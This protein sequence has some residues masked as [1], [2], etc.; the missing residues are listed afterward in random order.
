MKHKLLEH[1]AGVLF[2]TLALVAVL[3]AVTVLVNASER[4]Q[5][6]GMDQFGDL[7]FINFN[8]RFDLALLRDAIDI[9]YPGRA[10]R[11]DSLFNAVV[12]HRQRAF[13]EKL[14]NT[15]VAEKLSWKRAAVIFGMYARFLLIYA[16]VMVLTYYGV[17]TLAVL[18]FV[19]KK[20][21]AAAPALS[22]GRK[23]RRWLVSLLAGGGVF[24]LFC[25]AYVI[26]YSI[27]T[28]FNTDT[29]VFLVLLGVVSNGVLITYANKFYAFLTAE[30]RKGYV[31]TAMVK[32]L[33]AGYRFHGRDGITPASIFSPV[34]KFRNHVFDHVFR[35]ARSQYLSTIKEQASF[36]ITGLII[37]EMALNIH[38]YLNY[39]M[40]RQLL[41]RNYSIVVVM[42]LLIFYTVKMTEIYSD[43]LVHRENRK[44]ENA[45]Q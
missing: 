34:K 29:V 7:S 42:M 18:R 45:D 26:A 38:G 37:I 43:Y 2:V 31:A 11:N 4:R 20:R 21:C 23:I 5:N 36:V 25:P 27:R 8:S 9:Y 16:L 15:R 19:Y 12:R 3:G 41:Y 17:Q 22:A 6:A 10:D 13:A 33:S 32:N 44:Y 28:E 24:F 39:E 40:L 35:N 1:F 14:Q 30:A